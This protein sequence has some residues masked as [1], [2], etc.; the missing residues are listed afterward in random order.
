[1]NG[2]QHEK[3]DVLS[4]VENSAEGLLVVD[5]EG[6]IRFANRT[7]STILGAPPDTLLGKPFDHSIQEGETLEIDIRRSNGKPGTG[8]LH[9]APV[10][11]AGRKATLVLIRDVTE[12][13]LYDRLKDEWIHNVSHE[14]RTPLTSMR[15]SMALLYDGVLGTINDEQKNFIAMC[16]RNAD[17]LKRI[18]NNI[19]DI[20]KI[21]EKKIRLNKKRIDLS[22]AVR[23]ALD[24][25][26]PLIK[27]K[28]L[29]FHL[30][31]PDH[32]VDVYADNDSVTQVMNNLVGNAMKFTEAGCIDVTVRDSGDRVEC[33][34][35]DTGR[36]IAEEDLPKV[37]DKFQQFGKSVAGQEKGTGLGL[38]ISK[39]I[40]HLHGGTIAVQSALNGGT[41]FTF[42]IPR[43]GPRLE[44]EDQIQKHL[45]GSREPFV[46]FSIRL[47]DA[48]KIG[49]TL[50][51]MLMHKT[52]Q[53]LRTV[54]KAVPIRVD[55]DYA[56]MLI[57]NVREWERLP[58]KE[59]LR[60]VKESF[61]GL[62]IDDELDFTYSIVHFPRNGRT[63]SALLDA[64]GQNPVEEKA[65]RL[66]KH[67]LIVDD[68]RELTEATQTLL[69][70]F[71]YQYIA[72]A[73]SGPEAF[74][75]LQAQTPDLIIL[76]MKMPGMSGYE[77]I[78][79]LKESFETQDIPIL[80][81]S[82]YEVETGRFNEYISKKAILTISKPV[83][84]DV[85]RKMVYYLL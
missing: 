44:M 34:V 73:N 65:V 68:E 61:F 24:M 13:V 25:L 20:S 19:L 10:E 64:C 53:H 28:G 55:D 5:S 72:T 81:M 16:L 4:L 50:H 46:L 37:F 85:L 31:L 2:L 7:A 39:E 8:E 43:Y 26:S 17:H 79:R 57:E 78:G 84:G 48:S 9:A 82:G 45:D 38:A 67:I 22:L 32:P 15:E 60:M 69:D 70:L 47:L 66:N 12:R 30:N 27:N 14:L 52:A 56:L 62:G 51:P 33:V 36:G 76:D 42:S 63:P 29:E 59:L 71:G 75:Q 54:G 74:R 40:V 6:T 77:V 58:K 80:I 35:A 49:E 41:T 1:M 18:L 21:E 11:W 83:D 3:N 23:P